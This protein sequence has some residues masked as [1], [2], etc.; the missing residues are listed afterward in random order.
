MPSIKMCLRRIKICRDPEEDQEEAAEVA[1][2]AE[3]SA[4]E[5]ADTAAEAVDSADLTI[6]DLTTEE[7][8]FSDL[9][10]TAAD[11]WAE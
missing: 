10:F 3:D 9:A 4:A 11:C 7:V 1:D 2:L 6:T 5:A 8:G